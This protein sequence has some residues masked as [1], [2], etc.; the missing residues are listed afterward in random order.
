MN[1]DDW[2]K[3]AACQGEDLNGFFDASSSIRSA[4]TTTTRMQRWYAKQIC[5]RCPV[6][7]ECLRHARETGI[8]FGVY[9]GLDQHER[10]TL[11]QRGTERGVPKMFLAALVKRLFVDGYDEQQI[12]ERL[13][14]TVEEIRQYAAHS[15]YATATTNAIRE[16]EAWSSVWEGR[17][18]AEIAVAHKIPHSLAT[19]MCKAA[20]EYALYAGPR[21][22][23]RYVRRDR[24]VA[25]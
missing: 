11:A 21:E 15:G 5:A 18:P 2:Q 10:V 7:M 14:Y 22:G 16:Y 25:C 13:G 3:R 17:S 8:D 24:R 9:G 19:E 20:D 1:I 23:A 12:A 6:V 4:L